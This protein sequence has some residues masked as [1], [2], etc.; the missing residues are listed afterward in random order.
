MALDGISPQPVC[1]RIVSN[2]RRKKR[3]KSLPSTLGWVDPTLSNG[4]R[5]IHVSINNS[6]TQSGLVNWSS[7]NGRQGSSDCT[8]GIRKTRCN[9][10][11]KEI[12]IIF[13][14]FYPF[15]TIQ[16][17]TSYTRLARWAHMV[18]Q[19]EK[20]LLLQRG[21]CNCSEH[22][23]WSQFTFFTSLWFSDFQRY[24]LKRGFLSQRWLLAIMSFRRLW[25]LPL[26]THTITFHLLLSL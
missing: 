6:S 7:P 4:S 13:L 15:V 24:G 9:H 16:K 3:D 26:G 18:F 22:T 12:I 23:W 17:D 11:N 5:R 1:R 2:H 10:R 20:W 14:F 25:C 8:H 21:A 19:V